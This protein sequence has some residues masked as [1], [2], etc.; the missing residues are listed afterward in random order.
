M[1]SPRDV[2]VLEL[3]GHLGPISRKVQ[4]CVCLVG[5]TQTGVSLCGSVLR[6]GH[7]QHPFVGLLFLVVLPFLIHMEMW[8]AV[9]KK[10]ITQTN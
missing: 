10:T 5:L 1:N 8:A 4:L 2:T 7:A 6:R 9:C 3:S